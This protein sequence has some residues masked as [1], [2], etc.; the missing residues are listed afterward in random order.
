ML[1]SRSMN[2]QR[3][4]IQTLVGVSSLCGHCH[5]IWRSW[6]LFLSALANICVRLCVAWLRRA[7]MAGKFAAKIRAGMLVLTHFSPRQDSEDAVE[8]TE[9]LCK[10]A[11]KHVLPGTPVIAASDF[12][13]VECLP[14]L[15]SGCLVLTRTCPPFPYNSSHAHSLCL[16]IQLRIGRHGS[17][18]K[19]QIEK[20][21][22]HAEQ[23]PTSPPCTKQSV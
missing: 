14:A 15:L 11:M 10:E 3:G 9:S 8:D 16:Q 7:E 12:C 5:C 21:A 20:N 22:P 4:G 13:T 23:L 19:S 17:P 2:V 18:M 6:I 1:V